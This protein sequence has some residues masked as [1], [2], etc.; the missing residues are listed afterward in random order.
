M[1]SSHRVVEAVPAIALPLP[2][3]A[4]QTKNS[5][6]TVS[7]LAVFRSPNRRQPRISAVDEISMA[8]NSP[9]KHQKQR[10]ARCRFRAFNGRIR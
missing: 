10:E 8:D 7:L 2:F 9:Q 3:V 1:I 5:E 6:R 4:V